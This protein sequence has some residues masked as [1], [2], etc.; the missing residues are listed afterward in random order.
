MNENISE[1]NLLNQALASDYIII[2]TLN[3][4]NGL[5]RIKKMDSH[6]NAASMDL[7]E[8]IPFD[9]FIR[10]Y[11]E[12][13]V[14]PEYRDQMLNVINVAHL[15]NRVDAGEYII[16][17][18]FKS[19]PNSKGEENFEASV[20]PVNMSDHYQMV[21]GVK[22]VDS[23][24]AYEEKEK[25]LLKMARDA[26]NAANEAKTRFLFNMSHDIRTPMNA[27]MG[28]T[29]L[30]SQHIDDREKVQDYLQKIKSSS[31][32]LLGLIN[33]VL[34]VAR[35]DSGKMELEE[36][37]C[38]ISTIAEEIG[39][40]DKE[41]LR[42]AGLSIKFE[43]DIK[44]DGI[45]CDSLKLKE[46]LLNLL[47]NA[48]KYT[49]AGGSIT[50]SVKELPGETPDCIILHAEVADTGIGMSKEFLPTL[51][52]EFSRERNYTESKVEGTGLGMHIVKKL[53]D[54]MGGTISVASELGK[55]KRFTLEIPHRIAPMS[56]FEKVVVAD[57]EVLNFSGKRILLAEDNALNA[58][59]AIEVLTN[60]G[61]LVDHAEDGVQC[62]QKYN[63]AP[64]GYY[65]II[66]MD[67]QMPIMNG[68]KATHAIRHLNDA[69][70]TSIP[71]LALTANA[72]AENKR[73][74]LEAGMNGHLAKPINV[75]E[76]LSTL[77]QFLK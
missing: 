3:L 7:P 38:R 77:A 25:Q 9:P 59:I 71:I 10:Q 12:S 73:E 34:E 20:L 40:V 23:I 49:P 66:L 75:P 61:F 14:V 50:I 2:F 15:R 33:N 58:E 51:F 52:E 53:V 69:A 37:P 48:K 55:G 8:Q 41:Q 74:A 27:I 70:K 4:H 6:Q 28:Y 45:F 62:V 19:F 16:K 46:I 72:F 32:F 43:S 47:S 29:E 5:I 31:S 30:I 67:V 35:I 42:A 36:M 54:L 68:Y 17:V 26:A 22:C 11:A 60:A 76:L 39:S 56:L 13:F 65:D 63:M 64:A 18:R 21:V 24:V 44:H 1:L 57:Q